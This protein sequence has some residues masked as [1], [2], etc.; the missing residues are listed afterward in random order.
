M[1]LWLLCMHPQVFLCSAEFQGQ[2]QLLLPQPQ[3]GAGSAQGQAQL[4]A[5]V[6]LC[7]AE[8]QLHN[9]LRI[10]RL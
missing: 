10:K 4:R 5:W 6:V 7:F 9:P 2:Q 8:W 1:L 3:S